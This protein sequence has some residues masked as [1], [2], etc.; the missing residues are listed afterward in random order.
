MKNFNIN[1]LIHT[2]KKYISP[3]TA[4]GICVCALG[5]GVI[6][7]CKWSTPFADIYNRTLGAMLRGIFNASTILLPI[8]LAEYIILCSPVII[9][10]LLYYA[11]KHAS[12]TW[13]RSIRFSLSLFAAFALILGCF[14]L[15]FACGYHTTP[16]G[17]RLGYGEKDITTEELSYTAKRLL[18]EVNLLSPQVSYG[19]DKFSYLPYDTDELSKRLNASYDRVCYEYDFI[20]KMPCRIKPVVLSEP[21][22]YT[23]IA[24][25]YTFFTGESNLNM[26]FPD[27]TLPFSTAHEMA[28][29]RGIAREDEANFIAFLA[30]IS[31]DDPYIRYSGYVSVYEYVASALYSADKEEYFSVLSSMDEDVRQELI[32]YGDFFDKY[33]DNKVAQVS[34]AANDTFLKQNGQ[35]SGTMSYE[36]VVELAV[37]YFKP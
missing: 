30:C 16:L 1:K 15:N 14:N 11:I 8:S 31:S 32:A 21:W 4:V 24:G 7:L 37:G 19:E 13:V 2:L 12:V 6:L 28:H 35:E 9:F 3:F 23:H 27:Y 18:Y 26:N 10:L 17:E 5:G 33:R 36:L 22:T 25:V 34:D 20:Q 29:Q